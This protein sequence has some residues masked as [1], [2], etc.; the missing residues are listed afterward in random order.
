MDISEYRDKLMDKTVDIMK[1]RGFKVDDAIALNLLLQ[2]DDKYAKMV[3]YLENHPKADMQE[4]L[5][6][7]IDIA[8]DNPIGTEEN[9]L[10][11]EKQ[12]FLENK[13]R[14]EKYNS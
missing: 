5:L 12:K 9:E 14:K 4:L 3:D 13:K 6:V 8:K 11:I 2:D 10:K 1:G 7:G